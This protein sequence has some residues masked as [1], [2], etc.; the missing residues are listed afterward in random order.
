MR[1][2]FNYLFPRIILFDYKLLIMTMTISM[3]GYVYLYNYKENSTCGKYSYNE[4]EK[5]I[6]SLLLYALFSISKQ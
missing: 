1:I 2:T 5:Q 3:I 6:E 4:N